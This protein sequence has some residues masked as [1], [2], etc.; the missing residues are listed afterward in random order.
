MLVLSLKVNSMTRLCQRLLKNLVIC[1]LLKK[2]SLTPTH[3]TGVRRSQSS[4]VQFHNGL[5][6]YQN[7]VKKFW[8]KLKKSSST[9]S[10][11][12]SVFTI[13][14]V[15]VVTGLFLVNVLGVSHFQSS[16]LK[17][18]HQS[19]QLKRL[20]MWLNSL[21]SMALSSGGNVM[22]KTSCQK[23]LRIQVL[24]MESSRKKQISWTYGSTPVHHGME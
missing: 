2:K 22:P 10:G 13:W 7:S 6:L 1:F 4:G 17:M 5:L 9:Q 20:S 21:K 24:Q 8:M 18:A 23:D 11:V 14:F 3:L 12:K 19:W 16:T 15:T